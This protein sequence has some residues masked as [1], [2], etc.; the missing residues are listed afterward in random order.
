MIK[1]TGTRVKI[2]GHHDDNGKELTGTVIG[3]VP[4]KYLVVSLDWKVERNGDTIGDYF[5]H[6]DA[7]GEA[8]AVNH[9]ER[10]TDQGVNHVG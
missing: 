2:V 3:G 5:A 4:G 10:I 1:K 9:L 8:F 6:L 7:G